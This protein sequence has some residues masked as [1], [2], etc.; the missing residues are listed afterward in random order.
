MNTMLLKPSDDPWRLYQ[1]IGLR[2]NLHRKIDWFLAFSSNHIKSRAILQIVPSA[3]SG[4]VVILLTLPC[5]RIPCFRLYDETAA[6][7]LIMNDCIINYDRIMTV[8][9]Q[10]TIVRNYPAHCKLAFILRYHCLNPSGCSG[11]TVWHFCQET[12]WPNGISMGYSEFV[13]YIYI[14]MY[15][16]IYV[17]AY[18]HIYVY[19]Y[20]CMYVCMC[21]CMYVCKYASM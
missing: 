6:T 11:S 8:L 16:I 19:I 1:W 20:T 14:H 5:K 4:T 10:Y 15:M 21:V 17:Y 3:I 2:E 18:T 7:A 13:E 12:W 9:W